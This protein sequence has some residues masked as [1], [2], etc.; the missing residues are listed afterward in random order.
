M[1]KELVIN[2][3]IEYYNIRNKEYTRHNNRITTINQALKK[4]QS[5]CKHEKTRFQGDPAG[6]NDSCY[7]CLMCDKML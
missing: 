2:S 6:G 3:L 5:T 7:V 1:K 4:F